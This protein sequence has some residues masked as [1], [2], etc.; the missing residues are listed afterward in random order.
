MRRE[1]QYARSEIKGCE[2][3]GPGQAVQPRQRCVTFA[4]ERF[5][6][7]CDRLLILA[8]RVE[9]RNRQRPRQDQE[10]HRRCREN[11]RE[12]ALERA[13]AD[14]D[15]MY[16]P[17]H[18]RQGKG[19]RNRGGALDKQ[20]QQQGPHKGIGQ[21]EQFGAI[22]P[23]GPGPQYIKQAD[24]AD[25]NRPA[26][27]GDHSLPVLVPDRQAFEHIDQPIFADDRIH[28]VERSAHA[29]RRHG[30]EHSQCCAPG[31]GQAPDTQNPVGGQPSNRW[32]DDRGARRTGQQM[33]GREGITIVDGSIKTALRGK[34]EKETRGQK[35]QQGTEQSDPFLGLE[36]P[37]P[38]QQHDKGG[39]KRQSLE[40]D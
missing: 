23:L 4:G 32:Q 19:R 6:R 26:D 9:Q 7:F 8:D 20:R 11:T 35:G 22:Y 39:R 34:M 17:G 2:N 24:Q 1:Q 14:K 28:R 33:R 16:R 18:Q 37:A 3:I 40:R 13:R 30:V 27:Q 12:R 38:D 21:H 5:R 29:L 15:L 25:E 31:D 36:D 10:H